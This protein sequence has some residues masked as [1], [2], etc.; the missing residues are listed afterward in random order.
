MA[1]EADRD[2]ERMVTLIYHN[3]GCRVTV[4]YARDLLAFVEELTSGA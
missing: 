3:Y 1:R 4:E 2:A